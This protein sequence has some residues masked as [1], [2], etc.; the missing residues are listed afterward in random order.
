MVSNNEENA[1]HLVQQEP[2]VMKD[3]IKSLKMSSGR[4]VCGDARTGVGLGLALLPG[5]RCSLCEKDGI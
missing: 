2:A 3:E 1:R 5:R 4:A